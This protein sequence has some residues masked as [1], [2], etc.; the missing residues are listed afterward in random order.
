MNIVVLSTLLLAFLLQSHSLL[1]SVT[2]N[3]DRRF[4]RTSFY[5]T[6]QRANV[7]AKNRESRRFPAQNSNFGSLESFSTRRSI[8]EEQRRRQSLD[9]GHNPLLSL[10]LNLDA[11]ARARAPARAQELYQRILALHR[12]GYYDVAPDIVSFNSVLKAWQMN[13]EKALEFWEAEA[14]P[15]RM[16]VRSYNTFLLALAKAEMYEQAE[17]LLLQMQVINGAVRPDRISWNTVLLAYATSINV[18]EHHVA[19]RAELLLLKMIGGVDK[20]NMLQ[21]D[22][23]VHGCLS[24]PPL[25]DPHYVPP[26][27][28]ATTFNT[29]ISTWASHP[30]ANLAATKSEYWLRAMQKEYGINPDVYTYTTVIKALSRCRGSK[31]VKR[32]LALLN[33]MQT[34]DKHTRPNRITYTVA[35]EALCQNHELGEAYR[36]LDT[37]LNTPELQPDAVT[38]TAIID[39]WSTYAEACNSVNDTMHSL[40][41]IV[42]VQNILQKMKELST[43]WLDVTPNERTYTCVLKTYAASKQSCAGRLARELLS[44]MWNSTTLPGTIHYNAALDC[45]AKSPNATKAIEAAILWEEMMDAGIA[46]DTITYNTILNAAANSFGNS[47]LKQRSFDV[48]QKAF[49]NLQ[50]D[51]CCRPTSLSYNFYFK[52]VRKLLPIPSLKRRVLLK[53]AF[54]LC[55]DQ[56]CLNDILL[57]QL[58]N[59]T[60]DDEAKC[61]FGNN[62]KKGRLLNDLPRAWSH[63]AMNDLRRVRQ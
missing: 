19:E 51:E 21:A 55:C 1:S 57:H 46:P 8:S 56:G 58:L 38:F 3:V 59:T 2:S 17:S 12:E 49:D 42:A 5:E 16:N 29:V 20:G 31:V 30:N 25:I 14:V 43:Q 40:K 13:P 23:K 28:D 7:H 34:R 35:I 48:G 24:L 4:C 26:K 6:G 44:E 39:G 22:G 41:A 52:M 45:F 36:L 32:V 50:N 15:G 62:Y 9:A 63:N 10:N 37:M 47:E 54:D 53:S 18:D 60:T 11:L 27:P 33:E 61:V